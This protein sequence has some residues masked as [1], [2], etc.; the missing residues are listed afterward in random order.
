[1]D[2][3]TDDISIEERRKVILAQLNQD[4]RVRVTELSRQFDISEVTIRGD[5][6]ALE[7]AGLAERV[8][9]G[10][11][12]AQKALSTITLDGLMRTHEAEKRRIAARAA[13]LI[14]EGDT[15]LFSTGSTPLYVARELK[16]MRNLTV[17]TN[18][19]G[20][21]HELGGGIVH[22]ILLGGLYD[23]QYQF[24]YGDETLEQLRKYKANKLILSA[25]GVTAAEGVTSHIHLDA[26]INRQMIERANRTILTADG[27]KLGRVSFVRIAGLASIDCLVTSEG[28]GEE[29]LAAAREQGVEVHAV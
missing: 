10:A 29:T 9:G 12:A 15:V 17:V 11:V 18:S 4:G 20:V 13:S 6:T 25:D 23:A 7:E 1:M 16:A 22:V 19:V 27:S 2:R 5:L 26:E 21:A 24:T 8:H 28:G 3:K 14:A